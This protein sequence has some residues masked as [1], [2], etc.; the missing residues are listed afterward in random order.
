MTRAREDEV[1]SV[2]LLAYGHAGVAVEC[3]LAERR[4]SEPGNQVTR[5]T[6][7][8]THRTSRV[9]RH[10]S[11]VTRHTS[12]VTHH[13]SHVACRTSHVPHRTSHVPHRTS[14]VTYNLTTKSCSSAKVDSVSA[15]L[16]S[17]KPTSAGN[18]PCCSTMRSRLPVS[19]ERRA[20]AKVASRAL[21]SSSALTEDWRALVGGGGWCEG[22]KKKKKQKNTL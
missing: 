1:D 2:A 8:V 11:H 7:H 17:S 16:G 20:M 10:A 19:K 18:R 15:A 22:V 14:H 12:H 4:Q 5:R 6:S 9:T 21:T 3:K 13:T